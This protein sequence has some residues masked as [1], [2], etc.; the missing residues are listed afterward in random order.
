MNIVLQHSF[1]DGKQDFENYYMFTEKSYPTS[2]GTLK[3]TEVMVKAEFNGTV[4]AKTGCVATLPLETIFVHSWFHWTGTNWFH[5]RPD[6][7]SD[8]F[9]LLARRRRRVR[10]PGAARKFA[11]L[12]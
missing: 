11:P 2:N 3:E 4:P 7:S 12:V 10:S 5:F 6:S 8:T 1:D 9:C